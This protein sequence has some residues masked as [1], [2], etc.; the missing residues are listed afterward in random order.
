MCASVCVCVCVC[1]F[2]VDVLFFVDGCC[3]LLAA[4]VL[5]GGLFRSP[6]TRKKDEQQNTLPD[7]LLY[8]ELAAVSPHLLSV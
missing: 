1:Y 4:A 5:V 8:D 2:S 3:L 7:Q 6:S